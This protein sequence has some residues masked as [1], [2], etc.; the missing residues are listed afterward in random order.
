MVADS[1]R[2]DEI[3]RVC[4]RARVCTGSVRICVTLYVINSCNDV[5]ISTSCMCTYHIPFAKTL[6]ITI[7]TDHTLIQLKVMAQFCQ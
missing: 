6:I 3:H 4:I 2:F 7:D 5:F 1:D